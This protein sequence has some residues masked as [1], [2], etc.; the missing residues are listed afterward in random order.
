MPKKGYKQ[1]KEHRLQNSKKHSGKKNPIYGTKRS[2]I[3]KI[4]IRKGTKEAMKRPEVR[5]KIIIAMNRPEIKRK[6]REANSGE[7]SIF[8]RGGTSLELYPVDWIETLRR[9]IR[10]R[11]NYVCQVC[12]KLQ[13]DIAHA[14]HH[15]DYDKKN[16]NP[17]N[18]ITLCINCHVKTNFNRQYWIEYF[19]K[20]NYKK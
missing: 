2:E 12:S 13:G 19:N 8:W 17:N 5:R 4:K 15:I 14:I 16:C 20:L 18:L 7:N 3:T 9:S 1:T 6:L 11:D 10:E